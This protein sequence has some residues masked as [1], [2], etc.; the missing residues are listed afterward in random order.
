M[1]SRNASAPQAR[2]EAFGRRHRTGLVTLLF[3]DIVGSTQLKQSLGDRDGVALLQRHHALVREL[4]SSFG[5]AQEISTAGDSFFLV[6]A[7]PS[8]AVK[9][10]LLLQVRLRTLAQE[11]THAVFDRI[12]IHVG[13]VVIEEAAGAP[14]PKDLYG[15][16]VD[17]CARVMAVAGVNQILMTRFVFDTARQVL[18]GIEVSGTAELRWLNHGLYLFKGLE[19]PI[20]VCEVRLGTEGPATPPPST[21]KAQRYVAPGEEPVLGWRPAVGD[22]VPNTRWMLEEKLGEGGFGEVWRARHQALK[23]QRVFKFCF[24]ADRVR[25]LKREM[26]LFRVLHERVGEHP[27]IVRL[28]D[29]Y[30]DQPPYYL[31]MEYVAGRDLR[32]WCE[33]QGGVDK[34]PLELRL[35]IVAQAAEGLATAH[36]SGI[37]HRDIKPGNILISGEWQVA[38][39]EKEGEPREVTSPRS[40]LVTRHSSLSVKLTDFGIGQVVSA[41]YLAG[42]T[43]T[44]FTQT[45]YG[46]ASST[47]TGTH[48]YMAPELTAGR[49]ATV[50]SDLYSLGVVLYQL[51]VGDFMQPVATDW[52]DN[53][54]DELL[55]EDMHHCFAGKP[56]DRFASA[57]ELAKNLRSLPER[58]AT[59]V[60]RRAKATATAH[61][62]AKP[63]ASIAV[64]PFANMSADPENEFLS[65]GIA[66]DLL[67][68]L[69]RVPGLRVPGRTSC[70]AFKGK[71]ADLRTM[72]QMLGVETVL[73][74]S[75]RKAGNRLRIT[76]QLINVADGFHVWS[77]RYD[78]EM[79]DVFAVQDEITQAIVEAL[80][81]KLG[82]VEPTVLVKPYTGNVEAYELCLRGRY[83]Y[84][85]RT[86]EGFALALQ[87]FEQATQRDPHNPLAHAGLANVY[88]LLAYF[89]VLPPRQGM[90]KAKAEALRAIE[91]DDTLAEAH[92]S[93]GNILYFYDWDWVGA[94]KEFLRALD[95]DPKSSEAHC[96]YGFF[97]WAR[98]RYEEARLEL[99]KALES[100]PFSPNANW[101]LGWTLFSLERY[102]EV[103]DLARRMVAMDPGFWGGHNL[104]SI[105][106][107]A[108]GR[109]AEAIQDYEK[110]AALERGPVSLGVLGQFNSRAGRSSEARQILAQIEQMAR[111]RY[112]PPVWLAW[113]YDAVGDKEQA[114]ACL[115][116]A[117][118]ERGQGLVHLR[119]LAKWM[120]GLLADCHDL[121]DKAGL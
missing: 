33:D 47:R 35:E 121:L 50:Q 114:R 71:Q 69:S 75:V 3:S 45:V 7:K 36:A 16:H 86:P 60:E 85:L 32:R 97:L 42:V 110:V 31:V 77:E 68:A 13:E 17:A 5:E 58:R 4:L 66:E 48:L 107:M 116:R 111:E 28:H 29:V 25:S 55:R 119:G 102:D 65:D 82:A 10:A 90:P 70:F 84:Q 57:G 56:G 6:F 88:R 39:D 99:Q 20:E 105:V 44:G 9:F 46:E 43:R 11:T 2:L 95:L 76:A 61:P 24:R 92:A 49:P 37:L 14:K 89:G 54:S 104:S 96:W 112:V 79:A 15:L 64:L 118:E 18:R 51:V 41:E 120:P 30:L 63:M 101:F 109:W 87:F 62:V 12:G 38:S 94:E 1:D 21:E 22:G 81:S 73:E 93:L 117:I 83:H 23:E 59:L 74:G 98:S 91:L 100:D 106:N 80:K 103:F 113:A 27:H 67:T 19:E 78:R 72:G 108:K 26:T 52:A 40:S 115:E 53:I 34:V 8:D